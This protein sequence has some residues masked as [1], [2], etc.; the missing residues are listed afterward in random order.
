MGFQLLWDRPFLHADTWLN[1]QSYIFEEDTHQEAFTVG[2]NWTV[3]YNDPEAAF[4]WYSPVQLVIQHRGGEQDNTEM[5]VQTLSNASVGAAMKWNA[6]RRHLSHIG[7]EANLLA[8][9]QQSG[10]QWPFDSGWAYHLAAEAAMKNGLDFRAGFFQAP[11]HFVSLYGN[12]FFST[13]S[14]SDVIRCL[15]CIAF[16][17]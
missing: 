4:H 1:W 3:R 8:T 15:C 6:R 9:Y 16:S 11:R 14:V 13:L 17:M 2:S 12:H 5:G 10:H 7:A